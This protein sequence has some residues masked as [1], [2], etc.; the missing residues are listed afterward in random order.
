MA[1]YLSAGVYGTEIDLS[2]SV[3]SVATGICAYAGEFLKGPAQYRKLI[4]NV[5]ELISTFG[6][7]TDSNYNDWYQVA[8]FL[9][10]GNQIYV[11]RAVGDASTNGLG[12]VALTGSTLVTESTVESTFQILNAG[13][14]ETQKDSIEFTEGDAIYFI[15]KSTGNSGE[16]IKVSMANALTDTY[17]GSNPFSGIYEYTLTAGEKL[18]AVEVDGVIAE[19]HLVS[20]DPSAKNDDGMSIFIED[21]LASNSAYLYAA[22]NAGLSIPSGAKFTFFEVNSGVYT[23]P[24]IGELELA[25]DLFA[26]P[27]DFDC[28]LFIANEKVNP[29]VADLAKT[30]ADVLAIMGTT[31]SSCVGV[32]DPVQ[33][34]RDYVA[35]ALNIENSYAAFYGNY[36]KIYDKYNDKYRWINIAGAVAGSQVRTNNNRDVWWANAGLDRGQ[37]SG[38]TEI[39]FNPNQGARDSLYKEKINPIVSFPGQGNCIIW[40]QK[41]MLS[42]PSAF[43]RVNVR[44]LFLVIEKSIN[45]V[46]K[47]FVF[48]PNDIF[49]RAQVTAMIKPFLEDIKGRR[50]VYDYLVVCSDQNNT[51]E[52][53][54]RNEL[55]LDVLLKPTRV[56]E[57]I[58]VRYVATKTGVDLQEIAKTLG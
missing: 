46:M 55:K 18:L 44:Q 1:N 20:L 50:G 54:D 48:E 51:P 26:S 2:V 25:Y 6:L 32:V 33:G 42:R 40:G 5:D 16:V 4:T 11:V 47:Y 41:T 12:I 56:A 14:Y 30:R 9:K 29:Y 57:F 38:V 28:S 49:T 27:E 31:K 15:R 8:N 39:A 45:K 35:D 52:V 23:S 10:Y 7:P 13:S 17:D 21:V 22:V 19:V 43:D 24:S 37:I 36:V 58:S 3:P 53:I 34:V